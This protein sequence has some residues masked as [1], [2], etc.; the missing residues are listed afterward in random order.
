[1]ID[2][3]SLCLEYH[4]YSNIHHAVHYNG[5]GIQDTSH[6]ALV[7]GDAVGRY[8]CYHCTFEHHEV[9]HSIGWE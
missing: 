7:Y 6:I 3:A 5:R 1:M 2:I 4:Q 8:G 9:Y